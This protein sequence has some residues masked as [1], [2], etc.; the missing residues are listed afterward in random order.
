MIREVVSIL[1]L[2]LADFSMMKK[3]E[4]K[5]IVT[6]KKKPVKGMAKRK[7]PNSK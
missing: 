5:L 4:I 2:D 3:L 6:K 7:I 1:A